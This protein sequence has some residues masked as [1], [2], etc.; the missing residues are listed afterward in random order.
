MLNALKIDPGRH[1]KGPW[2]WF[3]EEMLDCCVPLEQVKEQGMTL[4]EFTCLAVCN[5]ARLEVARPDELAGGEDDFRAAVRASCAKGD[6]FV[7]CSYSRKVLGQTGDGHF[8]PVGAYHPSS[9]MVLILDVARFKYPPHWVPLSTLHQSM[10][11]VDTATGRPRGYVVF[12]SA[13]SQ[14]LMAAEAAAA[15]MANA[16]RV[17]GVRC[18]GGDLNLCGADIAVLSLAPPPGG[19]ATAPPGFFSAKALV[20]TVG[21]AVAA[22]LTTG[23]DPEDSLGPSSAFAAAL[24]RAAT[25]PA[26]AK[27]FDGV[28][29]TRRASAQAG[30][31]DF[32]VRK[33]L[34]DLSLLR[35]LREAAR[36]AGAAIGEAAGWAAAAEFDEA[37]LGGD[38]T[39]DGAAPGL[40]TRRA[41]GLLVYA[42]GAIQAATDG[43]A[44]VG[45]VALELRR[46]FLVGGGPPAT[47]PAP[48]GPEALAAA[49]ILY[50]RVQ[51]EQLDRYAA[52]CCGSSCCHAPAASD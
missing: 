34:A 52:A 26:H 28:R 14:D 9:D 49:S 1:W 16:A 30:P 24:L 37:W 20:A 23:S 32:A 21:T 35:L 19:C 39:E 13:H 22:A 46:L 2:R 27:L 44:V 29:A 51:R 38:Q 3:S 25:D 12:R 5:G 18:P 50:L 41:V 10:F 48:A 36:A 4:E 47:D 45:S 43:A 42:A 40:W 8:S 7:V 15:A 11:P 17:R 33:A 31:V 6:H